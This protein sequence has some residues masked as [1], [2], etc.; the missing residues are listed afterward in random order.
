MFEDGINGY[1]SACLAGSKVSFVGMWCSVGL[2]GNLLFGWEGIVIGANGLI[3]VGDGVGFR[4]PRG[5]IYR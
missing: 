5:S 3:I 4:E 1:F 2:G